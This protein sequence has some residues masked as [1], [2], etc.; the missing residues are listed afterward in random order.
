MP[1]RYQLWTRRSVVNYSCVIGEAM[2]LMQKPSMIESPSGRTPEKAPRWDLTGTEGYGG[3]KVVLWLSWKVLGYLR[4]YRQNK[5]V[6]GVTRGPQGWGARPTPL[7]RLPTLWPPCGFPD[8]YSK[9]FG[10]LLVQE[11]SLQKFHSIWTPFGIPFLRNSKTRKKQKLALGS[12][13]IG[14]SQK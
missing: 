3:G 12:R 10:C 5:Q 14:Q 11:K 8:V 7:A 1:S 6:G 4:I 9:S 2:V 13:L